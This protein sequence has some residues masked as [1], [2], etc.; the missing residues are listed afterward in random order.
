VIEES[1]F[2]AENCRE[3]TM[4]GAEIIGQAVQSLCNEV[5]AFQLGM[6]TTITYLAL[7]QPAACPVSLD[8][9]RAG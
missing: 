9:K 1:R 5:G 3:Q 4:K 8:E 6:P 2:S 7:E